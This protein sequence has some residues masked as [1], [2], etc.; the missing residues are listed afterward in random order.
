MADPIQRTDE[1]RRSGTGVLFLPAGG[2]IRLA[3]PLP[4]DEPASDLGPAYGRIR[5]EGGRVAGILNV[6]TQALVDATEECGELVDLLDE[7]RGALKRNLPAPEEDLRE[8]VRLTILELDAMLARDDRE[9][10]AAAET[11]QEHACRVIRAIRI[12]LPEMRDLLAQGRL[13]PTIAGELHRELVSFLEGFVP[14][15][16]DCLPQSRD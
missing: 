14:E 3:A 4:H 6:L 13:E 2:L 7:M 10:G 5:R 9:G 8:Q 12:A 1:G 11:V 15:L 16:R